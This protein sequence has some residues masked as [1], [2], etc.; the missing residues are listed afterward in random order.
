MFRCISLAVLLASPLI[1]AA[2]SL[3]QDVQDCGAISRDRPRLACFDEVASRLRPPVPLNEAPKPIE[4]VPPAAVSPASE[5][6][7]EVA[8]AV[9]EAVS[10]REEELFG[11]ETQMQQRTGEEVRSRYL[12]EFTGWSGKTLFRLENGQVWKQTDKSRL[13]WR[14][15]NP[16]VIIS[17]GAFGSFRLTVE[18]VNRTV[19]VKRIK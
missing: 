19:K 10:G 12:G 17:K 8:P 18:G 3:E 9:E 7:T 5:P 4:A 2:A 6:A 1:G 16:E 14:S 15:S 11:F 13:S